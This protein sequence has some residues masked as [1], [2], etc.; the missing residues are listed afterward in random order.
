MLI[1]NAKQILFFE[2]TKS[3][4]KIEMSLNSGMNHIF[5]DTDKIIFLLAWTKFGLCLL[6]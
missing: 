1:N 2:K 3:W 6:S 5:D 4:K